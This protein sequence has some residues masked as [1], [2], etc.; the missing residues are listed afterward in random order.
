MEIIA[1]EHYRL[2]ENLFFLITHQTDVVLEIKSLSPIKYIYFNTTNQSWTTS[3]TVNTTS[4]TTASSTLEDG[5]YYRQI[6][7]PS[8]VIPKNTLL[9]LKLSDATNTYTAYVFYGERYSLPN[10]VTIYGTFFDALGNPLAGHS[11]VFTVLNPVGYFDNNP[12]TSMTASTSTDSN[13]Y[14]SINLNRLYDYVVTIPELNYRKV[15]KVSQ[16][17]DSV[18][19]FELVLGE[20]NNIC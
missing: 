3:N 12:L 10:M 13:G 20:V 19:S 2:G 11:L 18:N 8:R 6:E 5:I 14:F 17:P 4:I 1:R 15:I 16:L 9:R 7:I